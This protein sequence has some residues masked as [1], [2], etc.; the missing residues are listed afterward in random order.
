M[1]PHRPINKYTNTN[2]VYKEC[3][4]IDPIKSRRHF[5]LQIDTRA[6]SYL[7]KSDW[8]TGEHPGNHTYIY[9]QTQ[10][11]EQKL[12]FIFRAIGQ[13]EWVDGLE[14]LGNYILSIDNLKV[15]VIYGFIVIAC[16]EVIMYN[17]GKL[18]YGKT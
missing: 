18:S 10:T 3:C 4:W 7:F 6:A 17:K 16:K 8:I 12:I 13:T 15:Y 2:S 5:Y 1:L 9:L 11:L 14:A